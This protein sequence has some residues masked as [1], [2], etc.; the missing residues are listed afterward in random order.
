V[1]IVVAPD[2]L[3]GALDAPEVAAAIAD[4]WL[5]ERPGDDLITVPV[6]DGGPGTVRVVAGERDRWEE[7]E[8]ADALGRPS[9]ARWLRRQD[10]SA[11]IEAVEACGLER[12]PPAQRN[13]MRTTTYGVG[14]LL[15]A[16]RTAGADRIVVAVGG[17]TATDGGA[18]MLIALGYQVEARDG[19][20]LKVGGRE[21]VHAGR[22]VPRWLHPTWTAVDVTCWTSSRVTLE[23]AATTAAGGAVPDDIAHLTQGLGAWAEVVERDLG[24]RWRDVPGSGAGGG[25]AFGLAAGL[26]AD[27]VDGAAAVAATVGLSAAIE[28]GDVVVTAGRVQGPGSTGRG[29]LGHVLGAAT[30]AGLP[31]VAVVGGSSTTVPGLADAEETGPFRVAEDPVAQVA[32]A[33]ARLAARGWFTGPGVGNIAR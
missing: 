16:A 3:H 22:L 27:L 26:G 29:V 5:R 12:L 24:G 17:A 13:P 11:I 31:A 23:A 8:V 14:Q 9:V 28:R 20:G 21:L 30:A 19:G 6:A 18:G 1:R 10:G 7:T 32:D 15:E 25:L 4:G 2:R 33:A